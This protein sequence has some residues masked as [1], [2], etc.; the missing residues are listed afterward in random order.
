MMKTPD[1]LDGPR[2]R[3]VLSSGVKNVGWLLLI[4]ASA[5]ASPP[6]TPCDE[7]LDDRAAVESVRGT[8]AGELEAGLPKLPFGNWLD[9][10]LTAGWSTCWEVNDCGEQSGNPELDR[11]RDFPTC[12]EAVAER[13][14]GKRFNILIGVGSETRGSQEA[15]TLRLVVASRGENSERV[16]SLAELAAIAHSP[17]QVAMNESPI[18]FETFESV[19]GRYQFCW[20]DDWGSAPLRG[21][22]MYEWDLV[23]GVP[24]VAADFDGNGSLDFAL[25]GFGTGVRPE[26]VLRVLFYERDEVVRTLDI[27]G[28]GFELYLARP[29]EGEFGEPASKLDGL[30]RWGEGGSTF[31]W[32]FHAETGSFERS[33]HGSEH[34]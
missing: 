5:S 24:C 11:G 1:P 27:P 22:G 16:A 18:R 26:R 6:W 34:H 20:K 4:A 10:T 28:A 3:R 14:D 7:P 31:V 19:F 23:R 15:G 17:P 21:F 2:I 29:E 9:R 30:V 33:E 8:E 13:A 25:Q 12:V 32:L